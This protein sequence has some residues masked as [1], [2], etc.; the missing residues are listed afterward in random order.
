MALLIEMTAKRDKTLSVF[1]KTCK[2]WEDF[3]KA[4][5]KDQITN[6]SNFCGTEKAINMYRLP[7]GDELSS[8][9]GYDTSY[10]LFVQD[11]LN[12][13]ILKVKNISEGIT[14]ETSQLISTESLVK[15]MDNFK[16]SF[17]EFFISN[18]KPVEI[19]CSLEYKDI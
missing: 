11:R 1:I 6:K 12:V 9:N 13:S 5:S 18:L 3:I 2:E 10:P 15:A 17:K 8:I 4:I 14:F 16:K 19:K 7:R